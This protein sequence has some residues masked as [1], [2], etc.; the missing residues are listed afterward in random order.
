VVSA[1]KDE[2]AAIERMNG[3]KLLFEP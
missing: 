2:P 3:N 1:V